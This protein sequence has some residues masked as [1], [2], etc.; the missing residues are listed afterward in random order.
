MIRWGNNKEKIDCGEGKR[1]WE[2][3]E[4]DKIYHLIINETVSKD[5][6]TNVW[7]TIYTNK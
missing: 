1:N 6:Y 3:I 2:I 5:I 7:D 4:D